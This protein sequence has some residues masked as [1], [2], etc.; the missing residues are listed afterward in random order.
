MKK[1]LI[2]L[3]FLSF[4]TP[5]HAEEKKI[6]FYYEDEGVNS[7]QAQAISFGMFDEIARTI[8]SYLQVSHVPF[9]FDTKDSLISFLPDRTLNSLL[10]FKAISIDLNEDGIDE[11][12]AQMMGSLVC[13]SGGCSAFI[14]QGKE[15]EWR[16]L[17]WY[18]PSNETLISSNKTNGYFDIHYSSKNGS[19]EYE[20]LCKFNNENYECE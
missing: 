13:G 10:E 3:L 2:T 6:I 7:Y 1:L 16:Q 12:I 18:F 15:K 9:M 17:G 8:K 5:L 19:T 20:Y 4:F 14:L 11:V